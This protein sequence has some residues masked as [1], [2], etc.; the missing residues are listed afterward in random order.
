MQC[1]AA[2]IPE[3]WSRERIRKL[4]DDE[5]NERNWS[6]RKEE[7]Y[8][9]LVKDGQA[10]SSGVILRIFKIPIDQFILTKASRG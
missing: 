10:N 3:F 5:E 8:D 1:L 9:D 6:F 4:E 7:I 2:L